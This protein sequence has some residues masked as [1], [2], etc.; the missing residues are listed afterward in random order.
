M[1][2]GSSPPSPCRK[3]RRVAS[4]SRRGS[5]SGRCLSCRRGSRSSLCCSRSCSPSWSLYHSLC[6]S[7]IHSL[8]WGSSCSPRKRAGHRCSQKW[9][10]SSG[11]FS[12][13]LPPRYQGKENHKSMLLR[14]AHPPHA[15]HRCDL[16]PVSYKD[17]KGHQAK[18]Q[19]FLM[20]WRL[21]PF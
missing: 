20:S 14:L 21:A 5:G 19:S 8:S 15:Q 1:F 2:Q 18:D 4:K 7:L 10:M 13:H 16:T 6:R 9:S 3:D 11:S 12:G 17:I